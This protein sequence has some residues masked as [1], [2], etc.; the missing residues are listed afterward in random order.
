MALQKRGPDKV[1]VGPDQVRGADGRR[2]SSS[3]KRSSALFESVFVAESQTL[4]LAS[5]R[6][7]LAWTTSWRGG[8]GELRQVAGSPSPCS[9]YLHG[10]A[11]GNIY[12]QSRSQTSKREDEQT[13]REQ[14]LG[15]TSMLLF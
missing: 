1:G 7:P 2:S 5:R 14:I 8:D 3:L 10:D 4:S 15:R 11:D 13:L 12:L 6:E 9:F